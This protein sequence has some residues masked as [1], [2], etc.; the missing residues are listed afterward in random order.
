MILTNFDQLKIKIFSM[1]ELSYVHSDEKSFV[2]NCLSFQNISRNL[3]LAQR[4]HTPS[5]LT[6]FIK[7]MFQKHEPVDLWSSVILD[8][9]LK[10][11]IEHLRKYIFKFFT[12]VGHAQ[13]S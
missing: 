5:K 7:S 13:I 6:H 8:I 9:G 12:R 10:C 4:E 11:T 3:F 2:G 1:K